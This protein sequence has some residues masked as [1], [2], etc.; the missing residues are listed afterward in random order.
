[1]KKNE[2]LQLLFYMIFWNYSGNPG[3]WIVINPK[4]PVTANIIEHS[5]ANPP[6][7]ELRPKKNI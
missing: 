2:I 6:I 4:L 1:M 7:I 3:F 5:N